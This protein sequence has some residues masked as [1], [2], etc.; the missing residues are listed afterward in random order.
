MFSMYNIKRNYSH[1]R[2]LKTKGFW[3]EYTVYCVK[4]IQFLQPWFAN[5]NEMGLVHSKI[6]IS[7]GKFRNTT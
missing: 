5:Y 2:T 6:I 7:Q 4:W 3:N 1:N